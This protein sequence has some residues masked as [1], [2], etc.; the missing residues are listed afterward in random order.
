MYDDARHFILTTK[1][2]FD[3]ITSDPIHPWVKGAATLYTLEYLELAKAHLN[4]GGV[5][6]EWVPRYEIRP[7][8][9]KSLVATFFEIVPDA[10]LWTHIVR[11]SRATTL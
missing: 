6:A 4:P 7:A 10:S 3:I 11:G 8:A 5:M 1:E 9:V 2:T